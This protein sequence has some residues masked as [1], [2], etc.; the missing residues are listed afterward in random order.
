MMPLAERAGL[1]SAKEERKNKAGGV[2]FIL[3]R[4]DRKRISL[5]KAFRI[6]PAEKNDRNS[7]RT[8]LR[9]TMEFLGL[10]NWKIHR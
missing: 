1:A 10:C 5:F 9:I 3:S 7:I 2:V 6:L 8:G 4:E